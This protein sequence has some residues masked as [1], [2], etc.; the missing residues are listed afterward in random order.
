MHK[1]SAILFLMLCLLLIGLGGCTASQEMPFI[2][3]LAIPPQVHFD[4]PIFVKVTDLRPLVER[5][6][7][8]WSKRYISTQ[9]GEDKERVA[10]VMAE[11]LAEVLLRK[12]MIDGAYFLRN[13]EQAP[14]GA[15]VFEVKLLSWYGRVAD[16]GK[17]SNTEKGMMAAAG[18][19]APAYD[20]LG[21]C[22]FSVIVHQGDQMTDL[23]VSAGDGIAYLENGGGMKE[24]NTLSAIAENEALYAFLRIL[25]AK[26]KK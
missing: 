7:T 20:N 22:R 1:K 13:E 26:F 25:E 16:F 9:D 11:G 6:A 24:A 19:K 18:Y 21:E 3:Y 4:E 5:D 15:T 17:L 23:G 14:L 12:K 8:E 2:D 10:R